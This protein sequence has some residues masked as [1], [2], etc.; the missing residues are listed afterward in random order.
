MYALERD[1]RSAA[2]VNRSIVLNEQRWLVGDKKFLKVEIVPKN[3]P[4]YQQGRKLAQLMYRKIW[5]TENLIDDNDYAIVVF[6]GNCAI[7]NVNI[8]LKHPQ[9][10]LKSEQFFSPKHWQSYLSVVESEIAEIS[11]LAISDAL[12]SSLSRPVLMAMIIGL[13]ML[14][15]V[16]HL[17]VYTTIQHKFLIRVLTQGLKLPFFINPIRPGSDIPNDNYWRREEPP[18]IYYLEGKNREVSAA[19]NSF[20]DFFERANLKILFNSRLAGIAPKI[21]QKIA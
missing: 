12:A 10:L 15:D 18:R 5:Q 21:T 4:F 20:W 14:L 16:K 3:H 9:T 11:G 13:K 7:A 17:K 8:Q 1:P 6:D 2:A 19:C